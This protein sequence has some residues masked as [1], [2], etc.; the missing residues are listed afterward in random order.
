MLRIFLITLLLILGGEKGSSMVDQRFP[1]RDNYVKVSPIPEPPVPK[2][3]LLGFGII[4]EDIGSRALDFGGLLGLPSARDIYKGVTGLFDTGEKPS[5][6]DLVSNL[7][8]Q[9][10]PP[11]V[12]AGMMGNIDVETGG[13]FDFLRKQDNKGEGRGLFQMTKGMLTAYKQFLRDNEFSNSASSQIKF[14]EN[15]LSGDSVY[16]IGSGHRGKLNE[17]F[18]KGSVEKITSEISKRLLRPGIPH[19]DRRIKSALKYGGK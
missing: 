4:P 14:I 1:Q 10:F 8:S 13:T 12:V 6:K 15:I 17:V 18:K 7:L 11:N 16:D 2:G 9:S 5:R 3:G 19:L